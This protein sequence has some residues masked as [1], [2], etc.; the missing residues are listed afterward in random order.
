M[1]N[2]KSITNKSYHY[3]QDPSTSFRPARKYENRLSFQHKKLI[4]YIIKIKFKHRKIKTSVLRI[5]EITVDACS[6]GFSLRVANR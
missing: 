3:K 2:T 6:D 1:A 5:I 4:M